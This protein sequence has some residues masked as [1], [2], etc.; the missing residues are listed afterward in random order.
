MKQRIIL[1]LI[2]FALGST[3][4]ARGQQEKESAAGE[5]T[6]VELT[7]YNQ[8][9]SLVREERLMRLAKGMSRLALADIPSTIDATSVFFQSLTDPK[10]VRVLEQNYQYDL[11]HQ[12]KL[13]EKYLG[14]E[15]EFV[16]QDPET[17]REYSVKGKLLSTG[18]QTLP[19]Y[20]GNIINYQYT[21]GMI[22][23]IN[24][25]I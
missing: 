16:R 7:I 20:G 1:I 24:G 19:T 23:E 6:G 10:G 9:L 17:K 15:V 5:R 4:G 22:A 11:V 13:L 12:A 2:A 21:G 25:Q 3:P 8:N 14:R 18:Y